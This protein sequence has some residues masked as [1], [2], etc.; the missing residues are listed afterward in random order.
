M[1]NNGNADNVLVGDGSY[2]L[3]FDVGVRIL[4]EWM[5]KELGSEFGKWL[6]LAEETGQ[7]RAVVNA[8]MNLL[9]P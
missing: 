9:V 1:G 2:H 7:C 8:E 3:A 5:S 4:L 6:Q